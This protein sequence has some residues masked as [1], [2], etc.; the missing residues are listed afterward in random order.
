MVSVLDQYVALQEEASNKYG[1]PVITSLRGY[2]SVVDGFMEE[3]DFLEGGGKRAGRPGK[4][5]SRR[6][7]IGKGCVGRI[8][9]TV[10]DKGEALRLKHILGAFSG[11]SGGTAKTYVFTANS[12][13]P[14]GSYTAVVARYSTAGSLTYWQYTG[15]IPTAWSLNAEESGLVTLGIDYNGQ[16]E[17][18]LNSAPAAPSYP[19]TEMLTYEGCTITVAG[20]AVAGVKSFSFDVDLMLDV[21]RYFLQG[22]STKDKPLRSGVPTYTGTVTAEFADRSQYDLFASGEYFALVFKAVGT[23]EIET[24]KPPSLTLELN[25][26]QYTGQTPQ[27]PEDGIATLDLSFEALANSSNQ[28]CKL[29][30]VTADAAF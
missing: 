5:A 22:R 11:P 2:E 10:M 20:K 27:A 29:T 25:T 26:C 23:K 24:G 13:G 15:L 21:D 9:S 28:I 17:A 14:A 7:R 1:V 18:V 12:D 4:L 30:Y 19:G 8:E 16:A 6:R 3:V